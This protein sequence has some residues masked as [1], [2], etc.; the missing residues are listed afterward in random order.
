M[1]DLAFVSRGVRLEL[2]YDHYLS[3]IDGRFF[4]V[5]VR[6]TKEERVRRLAAEAGFAIQAR[7]GERQRKDGRMTIRV[8]AGDWLLDCWPWNTCF[9]VGRYSERGHAVHGPMSIAT[10]L[11]EDARSLLIAT[12]DHNGAE[13]P[14][15]RAQR[16]FPE[17][18]LTT[19]RLVEQRAG[20]GAF[21][22][23]VLQHFG[24]RC[25]ISGCDIPEV[26]DAAHIVPFADVKTQDPSRALL[27]R[28][29]L[30]VLFDR[31][32]LTITRRDGKALVK[33]HEDLEATALYG[34]LEKKPP[35]GADRLRASHWR[36]LAERPRYARN[37][38][39]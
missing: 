12:P 28:A 21:R 16:R 20:Q 26:L 18:D 37:R 33:V 35:R 22:K 34:E 11:L 38:T 32:L 1:C 17:S 13:A 27:L 4:S 25:V 3:H 8:T 5:W 36:A 31:G 23:A 2:W 24:G 6:A 9:Y 15:R 29:D 39:S 19:M 7:V 10:A 30:H 14:T